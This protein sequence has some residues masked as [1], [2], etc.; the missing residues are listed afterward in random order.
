[1]AAL[2]GAATP[3]RG[4]NVFESPIQ[5]KAESQLDKLVFAQLARLNIE[6]VP[7]SYTHLDVYKRQVYTW[8][9]VIPV[10]DCC[11]LIS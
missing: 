2:C 3:E 9:G 8:P 11:E 4:T 1:V 7:V 5:P 10:W 6:P